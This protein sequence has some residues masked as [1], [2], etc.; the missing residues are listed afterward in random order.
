MQVSNNEVKAVRI[1]PNKRTHVNSI[2]L[3]LFIR[4]ID[5]I[6]RRA[7]SYIPVLSSRL[8]CP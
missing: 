8:R 5:I 1:Y 4:G 6:I 3:N 7:V 2:S